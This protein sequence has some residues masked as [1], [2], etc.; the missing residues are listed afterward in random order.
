MAHRF[1]LA[2]VLIFTLTAAASAIGFLFGAG[3]GAYSIII[4]SAA[5]LLYGA[6]RDRALFFTSVATLASVVLCCIITVGV[7]DASYDGMYFHKQAAISL[8]NGWSPLYTPFADASRFAGC[9]DLALWLDNYP[10]GVWSM[11][12][13]IYDICG[14]IEAAK[15]ANILFVFMLLFSA[16]DAAGT[17]FSLHGIKRFAIAAAFAANPVILSQFFTYYNDLPVAALVMV[18]GF[19][20]MKI[21]TGKASRSDYICLIAAFAGSFAVKFTAPVFCGAV[22]LAYGIA[23]LIKNHINAIIT[24][25]AAVCTAVLIGVCLLGADPYIKHISNG[26]HPVFPVMGEGKYDIMNTNPPEG[27]DAMPRPK[28]LA[29]SLFSKAKSDAGAAAE[30]KLPFTFKDD[31]LDALGAADVRLGGFGVFFGGILLICIP[32]AILCALRG[33]KYTAALP[34]IAAFAALALF[35]PESWWARYNPYTYYIPCLLILWFTQIEKV[36]LTSVILSALLVA[37]GL[38]SGCA[39]LSHQLHETSVIKTQLLKIRAENKPVLLRIND[40]PSHCAWFDE[41]GI[42]YEI[43]DTPLESPEIFYR[44]TKYQYR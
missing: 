40:F 35:F 34:A 21:Y 16:L 36:P 18:C 19:M 27:F 44:T 9:Q 11:Y 42:D 24:P 20:G 39:V 28:Q 6:W 13:A 23:F 22:L 14:K 41:F 26:K 38:I 43:S 30:L 3:G 25:C 17:I 12:A 32:L 8:A 31:E 5:I 37:N 1:T 29:V 33:K 7:Y 4:P 2:P 10:K 15:G